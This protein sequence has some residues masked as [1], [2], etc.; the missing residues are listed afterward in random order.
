[1]AEANLLTLVTL[2]PDDKVFLSVTLQPLLCS[3]ALHLDTDRPHC[4]PLEA[5][6]SNASC[7]GEAPPDHVDIVSVATC[8]PQQEQ[9]TSKGLPYRRWHQEFR[10][11]FTRA[12]SDD[13]LPRHHY[14]TFVLSNFQTVPGPAPGGGLSGVFIPLPL[15]GAKFPSFV[16]VSSWGRSRT[17]SGSDNGWSRPDD[18]TEMAEAWS[19]LG[20]VASLDPSATGGSVAAHMLG[21]TVHRLP[22]DTTRWRPSEALVNFQ[23]RTA[24]HDPGSGTMI[25]RKQEVQ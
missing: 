6:N 22:R 9:S 13:A 2:L 19:S 25:F 3:D 20:Y 5:V 11:S 4:W 17:A 12:A 14:S 7:F 10:S 8:T 16:T 24:A 15:R 23:L 1:M 18:N 21:F